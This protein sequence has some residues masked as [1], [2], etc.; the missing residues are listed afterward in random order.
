MRGPRRELSTEM[1]DDLHH[2]SRDRVRPDD[3]RLLPGE[4]SSSSSAEE[5][6]HWVA[7]YSEL[8]EFVLND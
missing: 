7:V 4:V 3:D 8:A 5:A 1:P 6:I 2:M